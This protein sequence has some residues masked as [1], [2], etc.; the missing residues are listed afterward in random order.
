MAR[1]RARRRCPAPPAGRRGTRRHVAAAGATG[2]MRAGAWRAGTATGSGRSTA[3]RR[4]DRRRPPVPRPAP[5]RDGSPSAIQ[6]P[7]RSPTLAST[8]ATRARAASSRSMWRAASARSADQPG[9]DH[10]VIGRVARLEQAV[11]R[12]VRV[13]V[14]IGGERGQHLPELGERHRDVRAHRFRDHLGSGGHEL[15]LPAVAAHRGDER[16]RRV[17]R[18]SPLRLRELL[19]EPPRLVGRGQRDVPVADAGGH[20]RVERQQPRQMPEPSLGPQ[21]V[22]RRREEVVAEVERADDERGR[23]EEARGVGVEPRIARRRWSSRCS[24]PAA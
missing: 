21:A 7:G 13:A 12:R 22:D 5:G 16:D 24:T 18:G 1:I 3:P 15:G 10:R 19:G 23:P 14:A 4:S 9:G 17:G 20:A 6:V 2:R 8:C 11:R